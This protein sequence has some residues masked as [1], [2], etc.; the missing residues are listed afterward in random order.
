MLLTSCSAFK[1]TQLIAEPPLLQKWELQPGDQVANYPVTGGLGDISIALNGKTVY[2]PS[3]GDA[4]IDKRGCVYFASA[5]TPAYFFRLC[6]LKS[7]KLGRLQARDAIA[8]AETLQFAALLKQ[9]DD[10]WALVE[11]DKSLLERMLKH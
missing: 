7:P 2:A 4:Y 11:P 6:G 8:T 9:S 1:P 5:E 10:K 3:D